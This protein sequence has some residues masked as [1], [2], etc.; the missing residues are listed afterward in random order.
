MAMAC[1]KIVA[2]SLTITGSIGVVTG[3]FNLQDLYSRIGYE[4]TVISRGQCGTFF[5]EPS[6]HN[7]LD[8]FRIPSSPC[9]Q[10]HVPRVNIPSLKTCVTVTTGVAHISSNMGVGGGVSTQ[11]RYA[12]L[13]N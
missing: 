8:P 3:K 2:E 12:T 1:E 4:K 13:V 5:F 6:S 11:P 9:L 10:G 7:F